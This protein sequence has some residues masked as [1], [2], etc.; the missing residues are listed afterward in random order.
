MSQELWDAVDDYTGG[1][2]A[3]EDEALRGALAA[4]ASAGLPSIAVTANQGKLLE[5]LVRT[6]R[7]RSVL[8]I[9]TL[10]G[11]STIWMARG[12]PADGRLVTLELDPRYAE[13]AG[14]NIAGAGLS[15]LVE[16]RVGPA[17]E[18]L[19]ALAREQAGPFELVFIDA[20]K[21][22]TPEY[23]A[24]SLE[25]TAPGSLIVADNVVR[26]GAVADADS[27]D[28][29]ARGMRRF[30]EAAAAEPRVSGTTIQ[31]VGSKGYDGFTLLLVVERPRGDLGI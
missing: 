8:E 26:R 9:G 15:S 19:A 5:L 27:E 21:R 2:L 16:Q 6:L 20:D 13:V 4:S 22:T 11:Y 25:L 31:T 18:S 3:S 17:L 24:A 12:L 1:L 10:G 14:A 23:F 28:E 7:A 30:L 29:G